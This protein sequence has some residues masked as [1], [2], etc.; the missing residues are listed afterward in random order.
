MEHE[1]TP[2]QQRQ[3][4]QKRRAQSIVRGGAKRIHMLAEIERKRYLALEK[5]S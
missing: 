3:E 4:N 2:R 5:K 1:A